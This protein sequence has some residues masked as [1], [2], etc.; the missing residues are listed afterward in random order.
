MASPMMAGQDAKR[1]AQVSTEMHKLGKSIEQ[2]DHL[3]ESVDKALRLS[4]AGELHSASPRSMR[5]WHFAAS[6]NA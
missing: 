6:Q 3:A 1:E 4:V 5:R 2:L